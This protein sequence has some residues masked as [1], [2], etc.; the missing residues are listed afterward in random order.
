MNDYFHFLKIGIKIHTTYIPD[1]VKEARKTLFKAITFG[2]R[3][4]ELTV[5]S[6]SPRQRGQGFLRP[7]VNEWDGMEHVGGKS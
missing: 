1:K 6:T 2:E 4:V 7:G 3:D 5:N